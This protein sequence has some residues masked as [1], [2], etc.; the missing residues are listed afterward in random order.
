VAGEVSYQAVVCEALGPIDGLCLKR[1][2][3]VPLGPNCVRIAVAAAGLNFP[4]VLM[5]RGAYQHRPPLPFVP[6]LEA[7]GIV[8]EVADGVV[9]P[10][11]GDKVMVA[12]GT[13]GYAEEAVAPVAQVWPMPPHFSFVEAAT[14]RVAHLTAYHALQTRAELRAGQ[15]LLVLGA[16]GG[17]GLASIEIGKV[18]GARVLAA[19]SNREKLQAAERMGADLLIDT[20]REPVDAAVKR[21]TG[22]VGADVVLDPVGLSQEAAL[23]ALA[24]NGKL[25]VVGFS[26]GAIPAYQANR[27]LLKGVNVMGVRAGEAGRRDNTL[28]QQELA[29]LAR[30]ARAGQAKPLVS[31][32]FPLARFAPAMRL[33]AERRAIGRVALTVER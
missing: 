28:R 29:T 27:I 33:L 14:F 7:A 8:S 30:L 18:L 19:A 3:R 2:P 4:D 17:I 31:A 6:G 15:T 22:G 32:S 1:L 16:A 5:I 23:R 21:E 25:L 10:A 26:A 24:W 13:G 9:T 12:L 11:V 20:S